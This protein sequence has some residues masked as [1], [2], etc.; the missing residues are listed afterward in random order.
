M[1][2][3]R[4]GIVHGAINHGNVSVLRR[5]ILAVADREALAFGDAAGLTHGR[6]GLTLPVKRV[7]GHQVGILCRYERV[8]CIHKPCVRLLSGYHSPVMRTYS[9]ARFSFVSVR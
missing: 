6:S 5:G 2:V 7:L 1:N 3:L 8:E 4:E 9:F